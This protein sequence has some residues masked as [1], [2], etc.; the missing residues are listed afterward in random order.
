MK[1]HANREEIL[2]PLLLVGGVI[3]KR[4]TMPI[5]ANILVQVQQG[6]MTLT[7]TDMELELRIAV[8]VDCEGEIDFTLPGRKFADICRAL[9]DGARIEIDVAGDKATLRSGR[10]RFSLGIL[11][12]RDYPSI[13]P[14]GVAQ[15]FSL[16]RETLKELLERTLFAMAQQDVRYYLNGLLLEIEKGVV[17]AVAT[18]GH[19]LA[20]SQAACEVGEEQPVQLLIPRKGVLELVK[21][22]NDPTLDSVEVEAGNNHIRLYLGSSIFTSKLIDGK[23]PDYQ[24]VLPR[25]SDKKV[26]ADREV[27]KQALSRTAILSNE[28]YRG[29]NFFFKPGALQ[30]QA[31]NPEQEEAEEEIEIDYDGD[32]LSIGFNVGYMLDV[33][34]VIRGERVQL[35]LGNANTSCLVHEED[36][37]A[38]RYVIMPMRL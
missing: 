32:E 9:P 21:M 6:R 2:G 12:A 35:E 16:P 38:S 7:A 34:G 37:E 11:P 29:I 22:L 5:L 3:E 30:M 28:K 26:L 36:S 27:L 8:D 23:Y 18:D 24:R 31:H 1:I 10:S 19:R 13:E 14:A 15:R 4:Q 17:R 20:L 33:L 25:N